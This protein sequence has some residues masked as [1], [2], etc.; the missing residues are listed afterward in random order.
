MYNRKIKVEIK[1]DKVKEVLEKLNKDSNSITLDLDIEENKKIYKYLS[2]SDD[3]ISWDF[4]EE[5]EN[6]K[7]I[8]LIPTI[9]QEENEEILEVDTEEVINPISISDYNEFATYV[10]AV[11]RVG[12]KSPTIKWGTRFFY[13]ALKDEY[14][15]VASSP[16][17]LEHALLVM[18][19]QTYYRDVELNEAIN[20]T[21]SR[22]KDIWDKL[23][24]HLSLASVSKALYEK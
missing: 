16:V 6:K 4:V 23:K 18:V 11:W 14:N 12:R 13:K 8:P 24:D 17:S 7:V 19:M 22:L 21:N 2:T 20:D 1:A 9:K 5:I 3:I 15:I 10:E